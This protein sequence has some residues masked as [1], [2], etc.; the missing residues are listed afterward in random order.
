[1]DLHGYTS[2]AN[3]IRAY[4]GW[5]KIAEKNGLV[6]VWPQGTEVIQ[7]H[8]LVCLCVCV[9]V[10]CACVCVCVLEFSCLALLFPCPDLHTLPQS[11]AGQLDAQPS[12]NAGP[13][14]CGGSSA[15]DIDDVAFLRMVVESTDGVDQSNVYMAGHSNG[16]AMAQVFTL[17]FCDF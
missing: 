13:L 14:C 6:I 1:M 10:S 9:C 3:E 5:Q 11:L 8:A 2:C 17:V 7:T 15:A 4:S 16:C 12:W